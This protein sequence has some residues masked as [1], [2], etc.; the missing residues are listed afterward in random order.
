MLQYIAIRS[1]RIRFLL[2]AKQMMLVTIAPQQT[3]MKVPVK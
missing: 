1:K 3:M 2:M